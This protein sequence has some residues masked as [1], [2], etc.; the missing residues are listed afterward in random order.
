MSEPGWIFGGQPAT[1]GDAAQAHEALPVTAMSLNIPLSSL[2]LNGGKGANILVGRDGDDQLNGGAGNDTLIGG[3][4]RDVFAFTTKLGRTNVDRIFD[5]RSEDDTFFLSASIFGRIGKGVV[6]KD[7]FHVGSKAHDLDDR[8]IYNA[9]T[10]ALSYDKDGSG[11]EYAAI[12]F[13]Q[14]TPKTL[15]A[16]HDFLVF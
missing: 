10:G 14:V 11:S 12:K 2:N 8:I 15:V 13:A 1:Y 6:A 5:F 9:K 4:G 16:A 7:A 3:D